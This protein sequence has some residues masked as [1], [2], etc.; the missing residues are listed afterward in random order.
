MPDVHD[1]HHAQDGLPHGW[2]E[3]TLVE[4]EPVVGEQIGRLEVPQSQHRE[5]E[6]QGDVYR[7]QSDGHGRRQGERWARKQVHANQ[8]RQRGPYD[9]RQASEVRQRRR[10]A[11]VTRDQGQE[12]QQA[13]RQR[14]EVRPGAAEI[15]GNKAPDESVPVADVAAAGNGFRHTR[16]GQHVDDP[17]DADQREAG[18]RPRV[19]H[20]DGQGQERLGQADG[21]D[22]REGHPEG[23]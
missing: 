2:L 13:H 15:V 14:E 22:E 10:Q 16:H 23:R 12:K 9:C 11:E 21:D 18:E 4:E 7:P 1:E 8:E 6:D 5:Q 19:G 17:E 3:G 20:H